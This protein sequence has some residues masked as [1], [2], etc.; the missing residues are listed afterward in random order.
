MIYVL[1]V[2]PSDII[3]VPFVLLLLLLLVLL[4]L[5]VQDFLTSA[6]QRINERP[7]KRGAGLPVTSK[8]KL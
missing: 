4:P 1:F 7:E 5:S 3:R 6:I 8:R 2:P